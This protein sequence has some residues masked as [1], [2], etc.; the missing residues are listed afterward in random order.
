[1]KK[2][3]HLITKLGIS[4]P[5][6]QAPMAGVTSPELVSTVSN[7]GGLGNIAAGYLSAT[8]TREFIHKVKNQTDKLFGINLF[9]PEDASATDTELN[10]AVEILDFCKEDLQL[11][12]IEVLDLNIGNEFHKQIEVVLEE[13][14]KVCSFTFGIPK[15]SII[16]ELQENGVFV[17]G[18][19]TSV[20]EA[21]AIENAGMDAVVLQGVEAGGHRGA[22]IGEGGFI[23]LM[24]LIPQ[25][26]DMISIPIIGA[27][28]IMDG[29]GILAA[30]ILG[31]KAVQMG[32]AFLT[33]KESGA[34]HLHKEAILNAEETDLQFT[35]AFSGKA[36]RGIKNKFMSKL[37]NN[38]ADLLGYPLQNSLT[39]KIRSEAA[40]QNNKDYMSMWAG[41]SP[42]LSMDE[43]AEE[44]I[45]MIVE[46]YK[47]I[48]S[49]VI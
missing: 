38:T 46:E 47:T 19:A 31:A 18:T 39:K 3:N 25:A 1:M 45:K 5:I 36:A 10:R 28:G 7:A 42:R 33:T 11:E 24:S 43:H 37:E 6:I 4:Y 29:R 15:A 20:E 14:L 41:Q 40:K 34:H 27:G 26:T 17:V 12:A 30:E 16:K 22:F 48:K 21:I 49:E 32:T 44:L 35:R 9:V 23:G 8:D 13:R 2:V